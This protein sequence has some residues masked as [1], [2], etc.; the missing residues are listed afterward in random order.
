[1]DHHCANPS[2]VS[3][4]IAQG[5]IK[6]VRR[7]Q[8]KFNDDGFTIGNTFAVC[9]FSRGASGVEHVGKPRESLKNPVFQYPQVIRLSM[10]QTSFADSGFEIA[11][12]KTRK[13][14]FLEEMN[15]V[16]PWTALVGIIQGYSPVAKSRRSPF[17]I[18]TLPRVHFLKLWNIYSVPA[19]REALHDMPA[20][21]WFAGLDSRAYHL[22]DKSTILRFRHFLEELGLAKIPLS[23]VNATL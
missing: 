3:K 5:E 18:E 17:P 2:P 16:V 22:P 1:M 23:E 13:L 10:K 12:K 8:A 6:K 20:Y 11:T 7:R 4:C 21:S 14:I 15:S 9:L 19:M